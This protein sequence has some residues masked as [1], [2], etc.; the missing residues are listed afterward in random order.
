M[1]ILQLFSNLFMLNGTL[2]PTY[3]LICYLNHVS[4]TTIF[5]ICRSFRAEMGFYVRDLGRQ[6]HAADTGSNKQTASKSCALSLV[7]QLF[8]LGCIEAFSGTLKRAKDSTVKQVVKVDPLLIQNVHSILGELEIVPKVC[9]PY[10]YLCI[11]F[12]CSRIFFHFRILTQ[13]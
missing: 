12:I 10:Y 7:R 13:R 9:E 4:N 5:C 2:Q 3:I 6:I 8:H 1:R 11:F